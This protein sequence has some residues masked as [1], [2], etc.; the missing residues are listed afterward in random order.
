[1]FFSF[2]RKDDYRPSYQLARINDDCPEDQGYVSVFRLE[3]RKA[4]YQMPAGVSLLS[5]HPNQ[6]RDRPGPVYLVP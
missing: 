5:M 1:M 4:I 2:L 3:A 6:R